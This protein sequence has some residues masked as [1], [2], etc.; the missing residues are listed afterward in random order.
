[1]KK[2][3]L[4]AVIAFTI[5]LT[6]ISCN[7]D[8]G[9]A[10][11]VNHTPVL[12]TKSCTINGSSISSGGDIS[13][14]GGDSIIQKG[15]CWSINPEPRIT[16]EV[17][18][19]GAGKSSFT[20]TATKLQPNTT[21]YIRA[22]VMNTF[23]TGYGNQ[24]TAT[25]PLGTLSSLTT[26]PV[27]RI[28]N[29]SMQSGIKLINDGGYGITYWGI[30]CSKNPNPIFGSEKYT[31]NL[32]SG[33]LPSNQIDSL[34]GLDANTTY[35]VRG[36][37]QNS[38]GIAY[39]NQISF[40]TTATAIPTLT[41]NPVTNIGLEVAT[42]GGTVI[43]EGGGSVGERGVCYS[44]SPNPTINDIRTY[45]NLYTNTFTS[46]LSYLEGNTTYYVRAFAINGG[47]IAYGNQVT[48]KT[49]PFATGMIY[50]KGII[51]YVEPSGNNGLM[52]SQS[53]LSSSSFGCGLPMSTSTA[54]GTGLSNT[55]SILNTCPNVNIY[56]SP[57]AAC[58]AASING[59]TDWFLPSRDELSLMYSNLKVNN[60][61]NFGCN[62]Y[63]SSSQYSGYLIWAVFFC[64]GAQFYDYTYQNYY[65]RPVRRF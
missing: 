54:V 2:K 10:N 14:D 34:S 27:S 5:S 45:D 13:N 47:G 57:A 63:W 18:N 3:I 19:D 7:K 33:L 11:P 30:C 52:C 4:I 44:T 23:E 38:K 12:T 29:K 59:F 36:Y 26:L 35:Y 46:T 8:N 9:N 22:Y 21:Y 32:G 31:M 17:T 55:N 20:S 40:T 61:G 28:S 58:K 56:T 43:S 50:K 60:I 53:D 6:I 62:K 1:M 37:A 51:F 48:F 15:I 24:I 25:T 64:G 39:G 16:D 41:T 65:V 49:L 42:S